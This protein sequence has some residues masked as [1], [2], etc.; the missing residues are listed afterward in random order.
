MSYAETLM[1]H[2]EEC[3]QVD[4]ITIGARLRTLRRWR[5]M[6]Q[7]QLAGLADM[8]PSFVSIISILITARWRDSSGSSAD[9]GT[10]LPD[11]RAKNC[12]RRQH[13]AGARAGREA[14]RIHGALASP[15]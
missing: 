13:V 12:R 7:A 9:E 2:P 4:E 15:S 10:D 5:G 1:H 6:T 11:Q 3:Q 14:G 8:S